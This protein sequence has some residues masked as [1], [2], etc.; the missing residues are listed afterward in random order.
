MH[1]RPSVMMGLTEIYQVCGNLTL[2]PEKR[3][4][5]KS[6]LMVRRPFCSSVSHLWNVY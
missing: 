6:A 5:G 3:Q 2:Q 1:G 4:G